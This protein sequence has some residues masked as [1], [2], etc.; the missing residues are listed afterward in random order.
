MTDTLGDSME[1]FPGSFSNFSL[2]N[3][4]FPSQS[5]TPIFS[6]NNND[7][8]NNSLSNNNNSSIPKFESSSL[9]SVVGHSVLFGISAI[10]NLFVFFTLIHNRR[11]KSRVSKIILH[12]NLADLIV[13]LVMMP[14]E[15]AWRITVS[16]NGDEASC[17]ILMFLRA[18][19]FYLSSAVLVVISLDRY[20]A[21]LH[22]MSF[23]KAQRRV[24]I[25]LACSWIF[26]IV[27]SLPQ[28][29]TITHCFS[30]LS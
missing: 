14:I 4:S 16:W 28:V 13:T 12:M 3:M 18:F 11:H 19:G 5:T 20:L 23:N 1:C 2:C 7:S 15:I 8:L 25:M 26:S 27:A 24:D 30:S 6:G 21:I 10:G 29:N 9:V 17:R 22:P